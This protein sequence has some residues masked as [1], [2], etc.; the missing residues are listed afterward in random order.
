MIPVTPM[1]VLEAATL[2]RVGLAIADVNASWERQKATPENLYYRRLNLAHKVAA[3]TGI[4]A[5]DAFDLLVDDP[6]S[7]HALIVDVPGLLRA[8]DGF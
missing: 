3:V 4:D 5:R 6:M 2:I 7:C 8:L 1:R